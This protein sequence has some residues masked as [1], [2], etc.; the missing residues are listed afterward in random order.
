[1]LD[2]NE[3]TKRFAIVG[4][5]VAHSL[6]PFIHNRLIAL[7]GYNGF[8][9]P[10]RLPKGEVALLSFLQAALSLSGWNLTMPHKEDILP[11]LAVI[12]A[13]AEKIASVNTV[14]MR[15]DGWYGFSSDGPGF[16]RSLADANFSPQGKRIVILGAGGAGKAIANVLTEAKEIFILNRD[17]AKGEALCAQLGAKAKALAFGDW[18]P[19]AACDLLVNT[20]PQGMHGVAADFADFSFLKRLPKSAL[21]A[22]LI[23]YPAETRFLAAAAA[24]GLRR[25]NGLGM[26]VHQAVLT[27]FHFWQIMPGEKE[28]AAIFAALERER[29]FA[30][31]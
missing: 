23:Y 19:L 8:Y 4:D 15:Q 5:P 3:N 13:G 29:G 18:S 9:F 31:L 7:A 11:H 6:S 16:L 2:I 28:I 22:D 1:M 25:I 26:L 14:V 12:D 10:I 30:R 17:L 20:T 24:Y 21:V 27:F